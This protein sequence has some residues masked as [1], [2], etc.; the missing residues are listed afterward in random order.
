MNCSN[1]P[2]SYCTAASSD[3]GGVPC[4][5][6]QFSLGRAA[7]TSCSDCSA[8]Y[9]CP[10]PRSVNGTMEMCRA[11]QYSMAG[12][13]S[14]SNCSSSVGSYCPAGSVS[15]SGVSCPIGQLSPGGAV[16]ACTS[17]AE[18]YYCPTN[19]VN[20]TMKV[21]PAG[22][23]S[24]TGWS[25]CAAC[26]VPAGSYCPA[27]SSALDGVQC[28]EGQFSSG[29]TAVGYCASR[30]GNGTLE[31]LGCPAGQYA[32]PNVSPYRCEDCAP[33]CQSCVGPSDD[34]CVACDS[35]T[36]GFLWPLGA[37]RGRCV[38]KRGVTTFVIAS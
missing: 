29:G 1:G 21:C 24:L 26:S 2:G 28:P 13:S 14:C 31:G 36:Y 15:A 23:Y 30:S 16:F 25:S 4:T 33:S 35:S 37:P 18:G 22:Q 12:W 38:G 32:L 27:G 3:A 8:G 5:P 7:N 11:G 6:G 17:C 9:V 34:Q 20:G 19:S 10:L